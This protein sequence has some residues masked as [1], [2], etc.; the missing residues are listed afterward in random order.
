M[1][2]MPQPRLPITLPT[3]LDP[4]VM[5]LVN[6]CAVATFERDVCSR[7]LPLFRRC[8]NPE[9]GYILVRPQAYRNS[10][11]LFELFVADGC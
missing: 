6:H 7:N 1:I 5:E 10:M 2:L 8:T 11:K 4:L 9:R 3:R